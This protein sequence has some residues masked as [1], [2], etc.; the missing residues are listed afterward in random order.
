MNEDDQGVTSRRL[1]DVFVLMLV[2]AAIMIA[3]SVYAWF[4]LPANTSIP[5]HWGFDGR[6]NRFA[7]KT[8]GLFLMPGVAV[9]TALLFR[10]I[11]VIEPRRTN[12]LR[13]FVAWRAVSLSVAAFLLV[14]HIA[15]VGNV[16]G[17][18]HLSVSTVAGVLV[19]MLLMALGNYLGKVRSNFLFGIRTPW[20]LTSNVTW[21]K[22]HR[23]GGKLFFVAGLV[24]G[25][26]TLWR[27]TLGLRILVGLAVASALFCVLYSWL[28]WRKAPDRQRN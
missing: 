25:V 19:G 21:D 3:V 23:L 26:L 5:V 17:L 1:N 9:V 28:V 16:L 11:P 15:I 6:P 20:T 4:R 2:M 22:T 24:G 13:S 10:L 27:G 8:Q 7:G 14:F 12:L 18:F